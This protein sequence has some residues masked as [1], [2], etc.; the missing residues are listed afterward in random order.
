MTEQQP[1][2]PPP[3][4]VKQWWAEFE[5][6][7]PEIEFL[8][9]I[10]TKAARWGADQ[11]LEACINWLYENDWK[12]VHKHLRAARRPKPPSLR[13]Q[14]LGALYTVAIGTDDTREFTQ[15]IETIKQALE[16]LPD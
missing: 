10:A 9:F 7:D 6:T 14:A 4:L 15:A 5:S 13:A 12:A 11:E 8:A 2:T 3:E 16:S 1:I